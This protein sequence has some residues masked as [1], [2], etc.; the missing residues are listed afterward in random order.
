MKIVFCKYICTSLLD[1][2]FD[3]SQ[4]VPFFLHFAVNLKRK[5]KICSFLPGQ[6]C[7]DYLV[8]MR[9]KDEISIWNICMCIKW[10]TKLKNSYALFPISIA[11]I[12]PSAMECS[13]G[14]SRSV[15]LPRQTQDFWV[16][17]HPGAW[18][19]SLTRL[20]QNHL[21]K[22]CLVYMKGKLQEQNS[23]VIW[24]HEV[25]NIWSRSST[26]AIR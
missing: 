20:T 15:N 7:L 13:Q 3:R 9:D 19:T 16:L 24:M 23:A 26:E 11:G 21:T 2:I 4:L 25:P 8:Q 5:I 6:I 14:G 10:E 22:L 18:V 17:P 12:N 1:K